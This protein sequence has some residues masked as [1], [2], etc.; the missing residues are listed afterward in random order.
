MPRFHELT[1]RD[2]RKTIRDAVVVTL[3]P[4]ADAD[5]S[6]VPGQYL[7]FRRDFGGTEI[8]RCYSIC[9]GSGD[10]LLQV[11]IKRVEGGAFSNWANGEL[12]AGMTLEAMPPMGQFRAIVEPG[13]PAHYLAFAG[14]SG[15]TPV[16]SILKSVLGEEPQAVFTLVYANRAV[17]TIM[18]REE[19]EDLKNRFMGR[20]SLVHVLESDAQDIE[21]FKGRVDGAKCDALFEHWI[22]ITTVDQAL[23]CGPEPMMLAI[24]DALKRHGL[25]EERIC[26]ELFLSAQPGRL[27]QGG[28]AGGSAP[29]H[30]IEAT[31][32]VDG[33]SSLVTMDDN[34]SILDAALANRLDVPFSCQ[35]GVCSTC[36]CRV[37]EGEVEMIANYALEDD[38]VRQGFVLACQ[39]RVKS[40]RVTVEFDR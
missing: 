10:G 27:D 26:F 25:P 6:F 8:R 21:L 17:D 30:T 14:G 11:G 32:I 12:A 19:L 23:I 40:E 7:T 5:F 3:D 29:S 39:S 1:V 20:F 24:A 18:F 22:D 38:E 15:I 37:L 13:K 33:V 4:P 31:I 28:S 2:V 34:S 16:L 36:R 9:A 35:A